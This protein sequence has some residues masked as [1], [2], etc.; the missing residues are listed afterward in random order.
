MIF[1]ITLVSSLDAG[2]ILKVNVNSLRGILS[3]IALVLGFIDTLVAE[4]TAPLI[5]CPGNIF[6]ALLT[7][8]LAKSLVSPLPFTITS[9]IDAAV[10]LASVINVGKIA[11][12]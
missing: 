2:I 9:I 11:D 10:S 6:E 8:S 1:L 5:P 4:L 12:P 3:N 7:A